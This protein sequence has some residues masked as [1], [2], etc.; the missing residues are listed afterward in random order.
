VSGRAHRS[1][2]SPQRNNDATCVGAVA[3]L[4]IPTSSLFSVPRWRDR[5]AHFRKS[6]PLTSSFVSEGVPSLMRNREDAVPVP[7]THARLPRLLMAT[8]VVAASAGAG[9]VGSY[10]W[11]LAPAAE[12]SATRPAIVDSTP[13]RDGAA[14]L[15]QVSKPVAATGQSAPVE[16]PSQSVLAVAAAAASV[17]ATSKIEAEDP[18]IESRPASAPAPHQAPSGRTQAA[19]P[20]APEANTGP[21]KV[22]R[23]PAA[24]RKV[25]HAKVSR[26][27]RAQKAGKVGSQVVEFAPNPRPDQPLRD[28]MARPAG[29]N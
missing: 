22:G 7:Q 8:I 12:E 28:F 16:P 24:R 14:P 5:P 10:I 17:P 18:S 13:A 6:S 20:S 25:A 1:N 9:Y 3:L 26:P 4:T 11:P 27:V 29:S 21:G 23:A 15:T 2:G 19:G